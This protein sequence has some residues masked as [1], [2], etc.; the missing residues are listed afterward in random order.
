M[1]EPSVRKAVV[2]WQTV[3]SRTVY[4]LHSH[5]PD[6]PS[7]S[8]SLSAPPYALSQPSCS[9]KG[10]ERSEVDSRRQVC[11]LGFK[12]SKPHNSLIIQAYTVRS[13]ESFTNENMN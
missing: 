2:V 13:E 12:S 7:L 10:L 6:P 3:T 9:P 5:V 4:E 8:L 11:N 1:S